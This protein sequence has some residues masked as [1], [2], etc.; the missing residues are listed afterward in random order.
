MNTADTVINQAALNFLAC[1]H[2]GDAPGTRLEVGQAGTNPFLICG[3]CDSHYPI[4]NGIIDFCPGIEERSGTGLAQK[5]MEHKAIVSVYEDYFRPAFTRLGSPIKYEE[6]I[7]WLTAIEND[8]PVYA[9][10]DLACGTGKYSRLLNRLYKPEFVFAVDISL[11]MLEKALSN[12][13]NENIDNIIHIRADAGAL[14][15][16]NGSLQRTNCFGALH[17]FPDV[18]AAIR[19][20]GRVS[21]TGAVFSCLTSRKTGRFVTGF[22]QQIFSKVFSFHFFDENRLEKNLKAAGFDTM[23]KQHQSMVLLFSCRKKGTPG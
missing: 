15:F 5:F 22:G 4:V 13:K 21:A 23:K 8:I 12:A 10:L 11:P 18:P 3:N 9:I 2:C 14:P 7:Q 19:E 6:E 17:L 20:I 16:K 1:P